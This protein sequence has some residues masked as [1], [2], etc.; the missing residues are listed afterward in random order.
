MHE[1][2]PIW[3]GTGSQ[4]LLASH[5]RS[6]LVLKLF[7][8]SIINKALEWLA[9]YFNHKPSAVSF[10]ANFVTDFTNSLT[11]L[12]E[13]TN[14]EKHWVCI[15]VLRHSLKPKHKEITKIKV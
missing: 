7:V 2:Y 13:F 4:G 12:N 11:I 15:I 10:K 6:L 3:L 14:S 8:C 5:V 9:I 1:R